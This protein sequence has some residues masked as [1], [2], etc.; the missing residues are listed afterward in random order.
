MTQAGISRRITT[1]MK[2]VAPLMSFMNE[3]IWAERIREGD[4]DVCDFTLGNPH[5][6]P[7]PE[8][9]AALQRWATP[10]NKDWYAYKMNERDAQEVVANSLRQQRGLPFEPDDIFLTNGAIAA[11]AVT[12]A[13]LTNPG[14][15]I[16]FIS[17]P[18][19]FYEAMIAANGGRPVRVRVDMQTFDLDLDAIDRALTPATRA[20]IVNSPHNP[21]GK[22][23]PPQTLEGLARRLT[24]ASRRFGHPIYLLSDESYCRI[25]YEGRTY[26]SPTAFY[27]NTFLLYTYGKTLLTPGQRL[28]YIALPPAMP[29]RA[30]WRQAITLAQFM[31]GY[32]FPNA[33]LQHAL[34]DLER[35]SIDVGHL[36]RKRD[37]MVRALREQGYDVH[38]PEGTFYLLPRSPLDDDMAF[39]NRLASQ[40]VFCLPGSLADAPG[41][42]RISLTANDDM[43]ERALPRF[44]AAIRAPA[45]PQP[46][47]VVAEVR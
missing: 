3:S 16:I 10:Q 24:R 47:A 38:L 37:R 17:P 29:D 7:L 32:A 46:G 39:I 33:L 20:I 9:S 2:M 1:T 18:W 15:E 36:Q 35:L 11:I 43:I 6:M 30:D 42:F 13:L 25:V 4:P 19:F 21:T 23:Y 28:G 40:N 22:L 31:T 5:D 8:F 27:P 41:Y 45:Q 12:L 34:P 44:A 14:D 26:H